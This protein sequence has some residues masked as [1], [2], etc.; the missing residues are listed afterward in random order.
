MMTGW[1][2]GQ[3]ASVGDTECSP[4]EGDQRHRRIGQRDDSKDQGEGLRV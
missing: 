1:E 4:A 2:N 3:N